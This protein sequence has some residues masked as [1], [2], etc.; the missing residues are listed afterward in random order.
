MEV[1]VMTVL[2]VLA[3]VAY[4]AARSPDTHIVGGQDASANEWPW[5]G[6][7]LSNGGFSCGCS[8]VHASWIITAGHCVGGAVAS[9]SVELGNINRGQ[10]TVITVTSITRHP[11][12]NVGQGFT[13]ND[14]A[15]VG[16]NV[17]INGAS[18]AAVPGGICNGENRESQTC[19]ITGWG[20]TCGTCALPTVLQETSTPV[21]SDALCT[22]EWGA[23]NYNPALMICVFDEVNQNTGSC[24]GDSGGPLVCQGSSGTW[25]LVGATSWGGTGCPTTSPSVYARLSTYQAFICETTGGAV[26]C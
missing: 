11:E 18:I 10:G 16:A 26:A 4:A 17:P 23:N 8:V 7:W 9:Y 14:V 1:T 3:L 13:P 25:D 12:Y 6:G 5:Q 19:Y 22:T 2:I 15:V 20:R 24:N 21:I